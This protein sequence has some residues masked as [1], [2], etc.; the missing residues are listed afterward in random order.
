MN[1]LA[2]PFDLELCCPKCD[3]VPTGHACNFWDLPAI[4]AAAAVWQSTDC[5]TAAGLACDCLA[6]EHQ[7]PAPQ[8]ALAF[9]C[10]SPST[11]RI[12]G[13]ALPPAADM[14]VVLLGPDG[15]PELDENGEL[16]MIRSCVKAGGSGG[17]QSHPISWALALSHGRRIV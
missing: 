9:T 16:V 1:E 15:K 12:A 14:K 11:V 3:L 10:R 13:Y 8:L 4:G 6:L 17:A 2:E 5:S 7:L